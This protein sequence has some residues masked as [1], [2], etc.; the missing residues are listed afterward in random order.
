MNLKIIEQ[1]DEPLLSRKQ[2]SGDLFFENST[3]SRDEVKKAVSKELKISEDLIVTD[4]IET[5]FGKKEASFIVYTYLNKED[6]EKIA[7]V[8]EPKK[9]KEKK[10][11]KKEEPVKKEAPKEEKKAEAPKED[12][13]KDEKK[14]AKKEQH[15]KEKKK[16]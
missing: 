14:E 4:K 15:A 13:P 2:V 7:K 12:K 8:K 9:P 3:P 6:M 1:K 10:E 5:A 16:K 11:T